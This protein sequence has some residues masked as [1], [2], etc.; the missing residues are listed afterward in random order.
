MK[1]LSECFITHNF[2]KNASHRNC[3]VYEQFLE[4]LRRNPIGAKLVTIT[5]D[6]DSETLLKFW[7]KNKS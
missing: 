5:D 1:L 6:I 3:A 2:I 4:R 7:G